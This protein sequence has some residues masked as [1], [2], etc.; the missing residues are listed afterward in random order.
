VCFVSSFKN[1]FCR[2]CVR[3]VPLSSCMISVRGVIEKVNNV[4]PFGTLGSI[5]V[6]YV[7]KADDLFFVSLNKKLALCC[8]F[9]PQLRLVLLV[10]QF[11]GIKMCLLLVVFPRYE[12]FLIRYDTIREIW[13]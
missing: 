13:N 4:L 12:K 8:S 6:I 7:Q 3:Y 11:S 5:L 10:V 9:L 2:L 1:F